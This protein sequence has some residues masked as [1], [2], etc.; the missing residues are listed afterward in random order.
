MKSKQIAATLLLV[1]LT[2][3]ACAQKQKRIP[4]EY[5]VCQEVSN[6]G[7]ADITSTSTIY[8]DRWGERKATE[9]KT[10]YKIG[11]AIET[12]N[13]LTLV[14]DLTA[15]T[16][17]LNEKIGYRIKVDPKVSANDF[18][19]MLEGILHG[20]ILENIEQ[21]DLGEETYL[22]YTC[23]K[24]KITCVNPQIDAIILTYGE[25]G[26]KM[27]GTIMG[28]TVSQRITS[29]DATQKPSASKFDVPKG[30]KI[31]KLKVEEVE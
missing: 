9:S 16:I 6:M 2:I 29:I 20:N 14:K 5:G 27:E 19:R 28:Q 3:A 13:M 12:R 10:E 11:D 21:T 1:M 25:L 22:N 24:T 15:W 31:E 30:V 17:D 8:F 26:M 7:D 18:T 4:L 23:K